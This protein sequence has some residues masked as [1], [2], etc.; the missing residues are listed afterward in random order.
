MKGIV[1]IMILSLVVIGL[2]YNVKNLFMSSQENS[3]ASFSIHQKM[4]S[5]Q[6]LF[7]FD[8]AEIHLFGKKILTGI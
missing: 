6:N 1:N 5:I 3:S 7:S 8:A 2:V 4:R